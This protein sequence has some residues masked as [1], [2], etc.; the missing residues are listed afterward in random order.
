MTPY[1]QSSI[2]PARERQDCPSTPSPSCKKQPEAEQEFL[3]RCTKQYFIHLVSCK[4]RFQL[5]GI[6]TFHHRSKENNSFSVALAMA[7]RF[8]QE[9]RSPHK[10]LVMTQVQGQ[11]GKTSQRSR[12]GIRC[13]NGNQ[14]QTQPSAPQQTPGSEVARKGPAP[15]GVQERVPWGSPH[16]EPLQ[17]SW[18]LHQSRI[19]KDRSHP[20]LA[21]T[22]ASQASLQGVG[23][24][25]HQC[26]CW[27][28]KT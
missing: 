12:V 10:S 2:G 6:F 14:S 27:D 24:R 7:V 28:G 22:L 20:Q 4:A 18:R 9:P 17:H 5:I 8:S 16:Q 15:C 23:V 1:P 11:A 21:L 19:P 26:G 3:A 13:I 25:T